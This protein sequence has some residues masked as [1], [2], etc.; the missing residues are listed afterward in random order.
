MATAIGLIREANELVPVNGD[1]ES[2]CKT[3]IKLYTQAIELDPNNST[4]YHNRGFVYTSLKNYAQALADFTRAI[5]CD[6]ENDDSYASR[7]NVYNEIGEYQKAIADLSKSIEL[8]LMLKSRGYFCTSLNYHYIELGKAY[9][10][11]KDYRR[12]EDYFTKA[13]EEFSL[14]SEAYY[15]RGL[16]YYECGDYERALAD[17]NKAFEYG[18]ADNRN[19]WSEKLIAFYGYNGRW[20]MFHKKRGDTHFNLKNYPEAVADF[21]RAIELAPNFAEA[22]QN[23]GICYKYLDD[24]LKAEADFARAEELEGRN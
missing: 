12:A 1:F 15:E 23:R 21:S 5:E 3:R 6:A 14:D 10:N 7:G 4:A 19:N 16:V 18:F 17:F 8:N 13:I 22:Y 20:A 9:R 11:L 24:G 2:Y